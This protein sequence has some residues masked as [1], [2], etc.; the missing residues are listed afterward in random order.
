[1]LPRAGNVSLAVFD[2]DGTLVKTLI[3]GMKQELG[4]HTIQWDGTDN[5]GTKVSTDNVYDWKLLLTQGFEAKYLLSLGS[6]F[7]TGTANVWW[8]QTLGNHAGPRSVAADETGIYVGAGVSETSPNALKMTLDGTKR[9]WSADQPEVWIGRFA[10][11]SAGD[12]L[13]SLGQDAQVYVHGR[14]EPN[15]RHQSVGGSG[16]YHTGYRW[17]AL[18]PGDARPHP[19]DWQEDQ[20]MDMHVRVV[21]G[22]PQLVI[23]YRDHDRV[24]W[25]DPLTGAVLLSAWVAQPQGV[26]LDERGTAY[27]VSGNSVVTLTKSHPQPQMLVANLTDPYRLAVDTASGDVYVAERGSSQ[28]I[29]RFSSTG[30]LRQTYG[31]RG[32]RALG[33]R[34]DK[35]EGFYDILDLQVMPG[36]DLLV[37]ESDRIAPR[38]VVRLNRAGDVVDEW[39]GSSPWTSF[40]SPDPNDPTL[41]WFEHAQGHLVRA[42]LDYKNGIWEID[43]TFAT[44]NDP[45]QEVLPENPFANG[46]RVRRLGSTTYIASEEGKHIVVYRV[47]ESEGELVPCTVIEHGEGLGNQDVTKP[48]TQWIDAN[49]DGQKQPAEMTI[50]DGWGWWPWALDRFRSD[51]ALGYAGYNQQDG[52]IYRI[53]VVDWSPVGCP[54]YET[55]PDAYSRRAAAPIP[56]IPHDAAWAMIAPHPDGEIWALINEDLKDWGRPEATHVARWTPDGKLAWHIDTTESHNPNMDS[57]DHSNNVPPPYGKAYAFRHLVGIAHNAVVANDYNGGWEGHMNAL[58][59]VWDE[60]GLWVGQLFEN[61]DT[62]AAPRELYTLSSDNRSGSLWTSPGTNE[63]YYYGAFD[64]DYRIYKI[65]GWDDWVRLEGSVEAPGRGAFVACQLIE[66]N[67]TPANPWRRPWDAQ[68]PATRQFVHVDCNQRLMVVGACADP[69]DDATCDGDV[70]VH[71]MAYFG[72]V[73]GGQAPRWV[74]LPLTAGG[75]GGPESG[76]WF[77]PRAEVDFGDLGQGPGEVGTVVVRI[78]IGDGEGGYRTV[79]GDPCPTSGSLAWTLQE[80]EP[81]AVGA[82]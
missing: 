40:I 38:R 69:L 34:Y 30:V 42:H 54:V 29:K 73:G 1:M 15:A 52:G 4:V 76:S 25:R 77:T 3:A 11:A 9:L 37:V 81:L 8:E 46:W 61:V 60:N 12:K 33:G 53:D 49:G 7:P 47:A 39:Y 20:P 63:V 27:V 5:H 23:T 41:V 28:R 57:H 43:A 24:Q 44:L 68:D 80:F 79:D 74:A 71:P 50:Y 66:A 67:E 13:Y 22:Q 16:P 48:A 59:Y 51:E 18:Y 21:G 58:T 6:T 55:L 78:C 35:N 26:E 17:D 70:F 64:A 62:L 31:K 75:T 82:Q 32:G 19:D 56:G 72:V 45:E 10:M 36:G 65:D 2:S 14:D